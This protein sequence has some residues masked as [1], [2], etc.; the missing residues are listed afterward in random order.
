MGGTTDIATASLPMRASGRNSAFK[1]FAWV[2]LAA[3]AV[4]APMA[5][6]GDASGHDFAFH[7]SSW[8]DVAAQWRQGIVYPRWAEWANWGFGEPRFIFYPP[9]SWMLGAAIGSVLPW[10]MAASAFIWLALTGAGISMHKLAREWMAG[11]QAIAAAILCVVNPYNLVIVYY[12]SAFGELLAVA[13]MPLLIW[14]ALRVFLL[15]SG[16][17]EANGLLRAG[18]AARQEGRSGPAFL[19]GLKPCPSTTRE[20]WRR[21][22]ALALV[23]AAVWLADVP[24]AVIATYALVVVIAV[25]CALQRNWRP[26]AHGAAGMAGGFGLAAFYILP[27]AW[28]Q[29]WVQIAQATAE[30][31]QPARNF[32][33]THGN[34]PDFVAFNWKVSAAVAGMAVLTAV[35]AAI[36][37]GSKSHE[38]QY[39]GLKPS[40]TM[41]AIAGLPLVPQGKKPGAST[42]AERGVRNRREMWWVL[43]ALA[44][45]SLVMMLP[46]SALLWRFLPELQFVQ[47][48]WRWAGILAIAFAFFTGAALEL[49]RKRGAWVAGVALAAAIACSATLMVRDAW[50]D[51]DGAA[52]LTQSIQSGRGYEGTDEYQPIGSDRSEL[53][54]NPDDTE[55]PAGVSAN[56]AP[57]VAIADAGEETNALDRSANGQKSA[58]FANFAQDAAP[59][60]SEDRSAVTTKSPASDISKK[61]DRDK[62][63]G[64]AGFRV[65]RWTAEEKDLTLNENLPSLVALRLLA[66]PA[67]QVRVDGKLSRF[68]VQSETGQMLVPAP[69]GEHQVEIRFVRTWDREL[70][71]AISIIALIVIGALRL[72]SPKEH[73]P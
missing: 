4:V 68:D 25:G 21:V 33:F 37:F 15:F 53:P 9:L 2:A 73:A 49:M 39:P 36:V 29:R 61:L 23:F 46:I 60:N 30:N 27:A 7:L 5:F 44:A 56:P 31:L 51:A 50:W 6:R 32:L 70:G 47:F 58:P 17:H 42:R 8:M 11:P 41:R 57:L 35:A 38:E 10:K 62:A 67:W 3:A 18:R 54:G 43:I 40:E 14:A 45:T 48:P 52:Y 22:P 66:Y 16:D 71:G 34:D 65:E 72:R 19:A 24:A 59:E 26:M 64:R 13:L 20:G 12:R 63:G 28:E 55:R 69:A 1:A